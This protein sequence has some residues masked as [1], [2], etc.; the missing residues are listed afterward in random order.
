[1]AGLLRYVLRGRWT[2]PLPWHWR[3][4]VVV[5][6]VFGIAGGLAIV[7]RTGVS[8]DTG[9]TGHVPKP[10]QSVIGAGLLLL[11]L[12]LVGAALV[13]MLSPR[14]GPRTPVVQ[15]Q[16]DHVA[17]RGCL[18]PRTFV[19]DRRAVT[20]VQVKVINQ[21]FGHLLGMGPMVIIRTADGRGKGI[22]H[23]YEGD[24][25]SLATDIAR[26][27]SVPVSS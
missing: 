10:L 17:I 21:T 13:W 27:A 19:V 5:L 18:L 6:G 22:Q 4:P 23:L 9:W 16:R 7:T 25:A 12:Y 11:G 1:M 15:F 26:W 14:H 8:L 20:E 3:R 2:R 24:P